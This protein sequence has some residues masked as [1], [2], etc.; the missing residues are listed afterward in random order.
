M[1]FDTAHN[2]GKPI[3]EIERIE[4]SIARQIAVV[5]TDEEAD[6]LAKD[7]QEL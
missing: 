2:Q 1:F 4:R 7:A 3:V 5:I 6:V